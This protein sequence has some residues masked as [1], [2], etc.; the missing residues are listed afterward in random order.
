MVPLSKRLTTHL[1]A[2]LVSSSGRTGSPCVRLAV[3]VSA[4]VVHEVAGHAEGGVALGAPVLRQIQRAQGVGR[5][6]AGR[7]GLSG[8]G[9]VQQLLHHGVA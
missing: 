1:T 8:E 4:H 6:R 2:Q 7:Q 5:E 3:M 9:G